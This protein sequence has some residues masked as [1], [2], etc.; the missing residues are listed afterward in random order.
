MSI[1]STAK[2]LKK[3]IFSLEQQSVTL[4]LQGLLGAWISI[5]STR[6]QNSLLQ[7]LQPVT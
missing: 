5:K 3:R 6:A 2:K 7:H 1:Q 4:I